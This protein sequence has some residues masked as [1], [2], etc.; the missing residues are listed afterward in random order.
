[1][2]HGI[3][4][5]GRRFY[6]SRSSAALTLRVA[7]AGLITVTTGAFVAPPASAAPVP[8]T[9]SATAPTEAADEATAMHLA[10]KNRK[11]VEILSERTESSETFAQ[12]DG[13]LRAKTFASPVRVRRGAGWAAVNTDLA[14][15]NGVVVP[16][17]AT[18]DVQ[19]SNGGPGPLLTVTREGRS[20]TMTWPGT[21]TWS[22]TLPAPKLSGDT[23]TYEEVM[24]GVD[25]QLTAHVDSFS[26]VLVVK[27]PT[28]AA[29]S[30]LQH[31]RFAL[32]TRGVALEQDVDGFI[33][34]ETPE[35]DPV[36]VSD[37]AR[38]WDKPQMPGGTLSRRT[39]ALGADPA[40][41]VLPQDPEPRR[42]EDLPVH[43]DG[44]SLTVVPSQQMLTDPATVYPVSIDPGFNGGKEIW[45][46]VS[47]KNP[48]KSYWSD[49]STRGDMRVG[50]LWQ[51]SSDDD[52]RTIVQFDVTKLKGSTIKSAAV[53][54]N[55][56]HSA[57]CSP[58]PFQLWRT[59]AVDKSASVTWN[60]TKGKWWK[61]LG[62]V[63]ATAN[64]SAC[65]KGNDEV[66]FNQT[67]V[68]SAF[69][70]ATKYTTITLSF[71]AKSESDDYQ[72]K[73]LIP[74]SAYLDIVYNHTPGKAGSQ[75][76]S[77]CYAA[78]GNGTAVTS[79]P[80]PTLSM[81]AADAD[82][83]K[84][85][86]VY[87]VYASNKSTLKATSAKT[88]TGIASNSQRPWTLKTALADGQYY[89]RGKGCDSYICG[90]YSDWFGF[91]V[92]TANP[93]NPKVTSEKYPAVGWNGGPGVP[94]V[95]RFAPGGSTDGVKTY[96]YSLNG[97]K[98]VQVSPSSTTGEVERELVPTKD[99]TN[100]LRVKAIDTAGNLSGA[101]DYLFK[102]RPV[103]DAW[104][105]SLDEGT[106]TTA[107][108][109]P[110]GNRP[111]MI[112]G[113]GTAWSEA[114]K[115]GESGL[116]FAGAG[117]AATSS[118]V[119][120]TL[121]PAGFTVAAWVRLPAPPPADGESDPGSDPQPEPGPGTG[122][123]PDEEQNPPDDQQTE[124][125]SPLPAGNH[126]AVSQDGVHTSMF[127]LGY[128]SDV[129]TDG[130]TVKDPAW[131]FTVAATDTTGAPTTNA[132]TASYVEAGAWVHLVGIV[133]PM[134]SRIQL[135]VNGTPAT[136][137]VL[138]EQAGTATWE[139][140]GKFA[141]GRGWTLP[142]N[143]RWVGEIDE[144][145][146]TPRVW[147]EQEIY[148][149]AQAEETPEA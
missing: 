81:K 55:V 102:V 119:L 124:E 9:V 40:G 107:A 79:T 53:L 30:E 54:V 67:A 65:P 103:G 17:A 73:K 5:M 118:T 76:F 87:E 113:T 130:D 58:S 16:K 11:P 114:G 26:Q 28:A 64:K 25:L 19:F 21:P 112:T 4:P 45:T 60:S 134:T 2:T 62:S 138:V 31:L 38:M 116:N 90:S 84:L 63:N 110:V 98:E 39:S 44:R 136:D 42:V 72:W 129:D 41:A 68:K 91:K 139:A 94:G 123:D 137:G 23:A 148:Q 93:N 27:T 56:R 33:R 43:L 66:R 96:T 29:N 59:N 111:A 69:Q 34:A 147:T 12:P 50:Q 104:Y 92:D 141:I 36:F 143:N 3:R 7:T 57:N 80:K 140:T 131:C 126:T 14:V 8:V 145:H 22:G 78:C 88:M 18:L 106:G 13:T 85:T 48:T 132:C 142:L 32:T 146:A 115:E 128:R 15:A 24:P 70:D 74:D 71:R 121:S 101:A 135:Y 100:T 133:N 83:G 149:K 52:W 97:A 108:S 127:Q 35:G 95:F 1:M 46:H 75:A 6:L 144:V 20:L 37:G 109:E 122:D 77:P 61:A 49:K 125:P 120:N 86:Y 47:R 99:L 10:W 82:G 89:W 105:W 117:D 51:S